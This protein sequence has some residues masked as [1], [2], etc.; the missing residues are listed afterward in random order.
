MLNPW[1]RPGSTLLALS[2]LLTSCGGLPTAGE[3]GGTPSP[4]TPLALDAQAVLTPQSGTYVLT[5]KHS[6]MVLDVPSSSLNTGT[7]LWQYTRNDSAAQHWKLTPVG[8]GFVKLISEVSGQALDVDSGQLL[9]NGAKVVQWTDLSSAHQ[10]WQLLDAGGGYVKVVNRAS[11]K[12]LD[13]SEAS[14]ALGALAIQWP[15]NGGDNQLWKLE[16]VAGVTPPTGATAFTLKRGV[17]LA[18]WFVHWLPYNPGRVTAAELRALRAS[19]MD[20]VR[21]PISP[22]FFMAADGSFGPSLEDGRDRRADLRAA[23]QA[24]LDAGLKVIVDIHPAEDWPGT[25]THYTKIALCDAAYT[26]KFLRLVETTAR[27]V[28]GFDP[29]RVAFEPLNEPTVPLTDS[30]CSPGWDWQPLYRET[31]RAARRGA[32]L[33]TI[34][35]APDGVSDVATD[36][37]LVPDNQNPDPNVIYTV[38]DYGDQTFTNQSSFFDDGEGGKYLGG[39]VYPSSLSTFSAAWATVQRNLAADAALS[40]AQRDPAVRGSPAQLVWVRLECYFGQPRP[41][42]YCPA[43]GEPYGKSRLEANWRAVMTWGARHNLPASR[44]WLGEFGV[45]GEDYVVWANNAYSAGAPKASRAAWL[46]DM[47]ELAEAN[48]VA[49]SMWAYNSSYGVLLDHHNTDDTPRAL[50]PQVLAALGL[51]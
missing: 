32:P 26:P 22:N 24:I 2:L 25:Q 1:I 13:V 48:G 17:N 44:L 35:V 29:A 47:R 7:Q 15:D 12:L 10:Q 6:G 49:W 5:A 23:V 40:P 42:E 20:H 21:L 18:S 9:N 19:G 33:H 34:V 3:S 4:G 31:Y 28:S 51:K 14:K 50:D 43:G 8:S 41:G 46:R 27:F 36:D 45:Q 38:H 30:V 11:G 37:G 16:A 39:L